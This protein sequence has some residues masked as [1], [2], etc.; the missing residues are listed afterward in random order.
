M[1]NTWLS[2]VKCAS[3]GFNICK[4]TYTFKFIKVLYILT[5]A[6]VKKIWLEQNCILASIFSVKKLYVNL[7]VPLRFHDI[8]LMT[9]SY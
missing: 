3:S 9:F 5:L 8:N 6:I 2:C 4:S 1:V 7:V